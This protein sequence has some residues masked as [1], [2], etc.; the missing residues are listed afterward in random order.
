MIF[1][2]KIRI[3]SFYIEKIRFFTENSVSKFAHIGSTNGSREWALFK[4]Y[5]YVFI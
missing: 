1:K 3:K 2:A 5:E 4:M